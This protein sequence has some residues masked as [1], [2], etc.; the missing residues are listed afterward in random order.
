MPSVTRSTPRSHLP[1]RELLEILLPA[2]APCQ[3]F[4]ATCKTMRWRPEDGHIPRG[5]CG[6]T[7]A[8]QEVEV[9]LIV[10]EPGDPHAF[11]AYEA[12]SSPLEKL[13][14]VFDYAYR[15]FE[16][17]HDRF[18]KNVAYIL[19]SCWP[20]LPFAD[21]MRRVWITESSLCSAVQEGGHVP[22]AVHRQCRDQYL[23]AQLTLLSGRTIVA[24]GK[25][26]QDRIGRDP[27]LV[28]ASSVA[29]PGCNFKGAKQSWNRVAEIVRSRRDQSSGAV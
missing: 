17:G 28:V 2:Y 20:E 27:N 3:H 14:T 12:S 9:V 5:F 1:C 16:V 21:R 26:A 24:L 8:L 15:C 29:P 13:S 7:G 23:Q 22:S 6:A 19:E 25:K 11:E 4:G 10:A 18:H